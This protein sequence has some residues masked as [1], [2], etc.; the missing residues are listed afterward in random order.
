MTQSKITYRDVSHDP[1]AVIKALSDPEIRLALSD[2][3]FASIGFLKVS[4][5]GMNTQKQLEEWLSSVDA[6][7]IMDRMENGEIAEVWGSGDKTTFADIDNHFGEL[8]VS[9]A[10]IT[11]NG[12]I[13]DTTMKPKRGPK[14]SPKITGVARTTLFNLRNQIDAKLRKLERGLPPLWP[15]SDRPKAGYHIELVETSDIKRLWARHQARLREFIE[16]DQKIVSHDNLKLH[17]CISSRRM[18][19]IEYIGKWYRRLFVTNIG[20]NVVLSIL[21]M[22]EEFLIFDFLRFLPYI[23]Y[24]AILILLLTIPFMTILQYLGFALIRESILPELPGPKLEDVDTLM[25]KIILN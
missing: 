11:E 3:G 19:I 5:P 2:C 7:F 18:H 12:V 10:T 6:A 14:A 24:P 22:T 8:I 21:L 20:L 17:Q 1:E 13:V 9:F 16:K 25:G 4:A 23:I 15:R